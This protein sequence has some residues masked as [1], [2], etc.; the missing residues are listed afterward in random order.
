MLSVLC[1]LLSVPCRTVPYT[2]PPWFTMTCAR[3]A[4]W[5]QV[6]IRHANPAGTF[7]VVN[8]SLSEAAAL[9]FEYGYS[10]TSGED[11][12]VWEAQFGDFLNT[13]QSIV[14]TFIATGEHRWYAQSALTILLPHGFEGQGPDHSSARVER[15]LQLCADDPDNVPGQSPAQLAAVQHGELGGGVC[16]R[17]RR[18]TT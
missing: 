4:M 7:R 2:H 14:D 8:S 6:P 10:L 1:C 3:T 13:A 15:I 17:A 11:L 12:V 9:G 16:T 5:P 18:G